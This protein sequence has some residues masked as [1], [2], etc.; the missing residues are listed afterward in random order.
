L[1]FVIPAQAEIQ[2]YD[3]HSRA[4]GNPVLRLS[5]PRR[6]ESSFTIVIPAQ[7]GIQFLR[8]SFPRRRESSFTF[9]I[10]A[11]AGIQF[12]YNYRYMAVVLRVV[13]SWMPL[14]SNLRWNDEPRG[15]LLFSD[16]PF[17]LNDNESLTLPE[18]RLCKK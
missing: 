9:V 12:L 3:C 5:F 8:L 11:Q 6:R 7:A 17:C 13:T 1:T 15:N 2:F 16:T 10:P 18:I 14:D 4:G